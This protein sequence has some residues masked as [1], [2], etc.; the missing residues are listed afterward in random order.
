MQQTLGN[1]AVVVTYPAPLVSGGDEPVTVTCS[2]AS[3]SSFPVGTTV[4]GCTALD[5]RHRTAACGFPVTV[6]NVPQI[7]A[8]KYVAFGDSITE[9]QIDSTCPSRAALTLADALLDLRVGA[10]IVDPSRSYPTKVQ[11]LLSAR[12]PAQTITMFNAGRGGERVDDGVVRL[13]GVLTAQVPQ[14]LLL[15]E[16][17]NDINSIAFGVAPTTVMSTLVNGLRS[18]IREARRRGIVVFVGTL[19]PQRPGAC[20]GYAPAYI[21]PANDVIRVMVAGEGSGVTLV[22]L[23][24]AFGGVAGDLLSED[25]L[26]PNE[27]GYQRIAQTF[28]DSIQQRL[29]TVAAAVGSQL[30]VG[31]GTSTFLRRTV[32]VGS[33]P[34]AAG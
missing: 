8:T 14:V 13:P 33:K 16:G 23:Y 19:I 7:S 10:R 25:G 11:Q 2:P 24:A 6:L 27:A 20:R 5:A 34:R 4:V 18:M 22:D 17:A 21:A 29:E 3:G 15:Q 26:H 9:G 12:Y 1:Q 30:P 32:V 28:V 31:G